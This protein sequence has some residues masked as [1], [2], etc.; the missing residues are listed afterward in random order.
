MAARVAVP[1][2]QILD[3]LPS[4]CSSVMFFPAG[5]HRRQQRGLRV[6]RLGQGLLLRQSMSHDRNG[7]VFGNPPSPLSRSGLVLS[8][9]LL[10]G[11]HAAPARSDNGGR[12]G[13]ERHSLAG[14][15]HDQKF[16]LAGWRECFQHPSGYQGV[17][18]RFRL[19]QPFGDD[20][21]DN[22]GMVE[23]VTFVSSTL[24]VFRL[25]GRKTVRIPLNSGMET[26]FPSK[27]GMYSM[28]SSGIWRLPRPRIRNKASF[29]TRIGRWRGSSPLSGHNGRCNLLKRGQVVQ[30]RGLLES[31][32]V[33]RPSDCCHRTG[34]DFPV[35]RLCRILL[36]E[37]FRVDE[38][39]VR[40]PAVSA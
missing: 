6:Q 7:L 28:T 29:H 9:S 19:G 8:L 5:L 3:G 12:A 25:T 1:H 38:H 37:L 13:T 22:K 34:S 39:A 21:R 36:L 23:M 14:T 16:L 24:R 33:F 30:K 15:F 20:T 18:G 2:A 35:C 26:T 4:A 11:E 10:S 31:L 40:A 27:E 32:L 17:N